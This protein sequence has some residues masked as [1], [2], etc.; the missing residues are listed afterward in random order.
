MLLIPEYCP[1]NVWNNIWQMLT[2]D[3]SQGYLYKAILRKL[4]VNQTTKLLSSI[5]ENIVGKG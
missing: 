4:T 5:M 3:A 1:M 2:I